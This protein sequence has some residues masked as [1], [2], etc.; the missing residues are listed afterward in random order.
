M[1]KEY[2]VLKED[3]FFAK[4]KT[5]AGIKVKI[6]NTTTEKDFKLSPATVALL[7]LCTGTHCVDEIIRELSEQSGELVEDLIE[8]VTS[9]LTVLQEKGLITMES[10]PLEKGVSKAKEVNT[11]YPIEAAEIE[12]TNRCN[13][14]CMHCVNNSGEPY[15]SELTTEEILSLIDILSS[16]GATR[17]TLSGGEPLLHPDFFRI[18]AHTRKAPMTVYIFTNGTLLTEDTVEKFV[19]LGVKQVATSIDSMDEN[20]HDTFRGQKGALKQTLR[21]I[22]LL[23]R[24]GISV[25]V[26][27]SIVQV[28][29]NHFIDI[30]KYLKDENLTDYQIAP[31]KFS[32]RGREGVTISPEEFYT[33]LVEQFHYLK[34][35][36]PDETL[37]VNPKS[38]GGCGMAQD[39]I[40][41]KADGTVLPCHGCYRVMGW[42]NVRN[43]DLEVWWDTDE[44]LE[45]LRG[46]RTEKDK[47]C[48][49]CTYLAFCDGCIANAFLLEKEFRCYDPYT[50][51]HYR[52]YEEVF[53]FT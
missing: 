46:L 51:A 18:V 53:G 17:I 6:H 9:I 16:M 48:M 45:M 5:P 14:S 31:V 28:N 8:G 13:L 19:R 30:L 35:E 24:A 12:I 42:E 2:P 26:S 38:E 11:R 39:D 29:K 37:K 4:I 43:I 21:A 34:E 49:K 23:K 33:V 41:I 27:L 7:D 15:P 50:C 52:A 36:T 32:G 47:T 44:T 1:T 20:I 10:N 40:Y 25:R 3:I 22:N